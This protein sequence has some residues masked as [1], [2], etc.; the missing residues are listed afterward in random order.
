MRY[1]NRH[2]LYFYLDVVGVF[3]S[4]GLSCLVPAT[5]LASLI[6]QHVTFV[7]LFLFGASYVLGAVVYA[8]RV[9]ESI[10]PGRFDTWVMIIIA[11]NV[12][13]SVRPSVCLSV[14][15]SN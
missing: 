14:C 6:G 5:H 3:L 4:L 7:Y 12:R 15:P 9:P 1:T 13:L 11:T 8:T 10:W 2:Y